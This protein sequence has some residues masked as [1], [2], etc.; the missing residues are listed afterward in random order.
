[1][2][3]LQNFSKIKAFVFDVDG[4]LTDSSVLVLN[5]GQQA[6]R[7]NIKDGYALQLAAKKGYKILV[8]SGGT[9]EAVR[10]RLTKLGISDVHLDVADK[11]TIFTAY[12]NEHQLITEQILYMGD[13]IP[14]LAVM[15]M[16]GLACCPADAVAEIKQVSHYISSFNGGEG[17]VRD[18]IE[19][20]LKLN[21]D[22][23][24]D[25]DVKSK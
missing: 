23:H 3:V 16:S 11:R 5:D 24:H 15:K 10:D 25:T 1:M 12:I 2:N 4:V 19:K 6:R 8:I 14:D 9:S 13:D 7:M 21:G 20:V 17:C 18:V 22:W